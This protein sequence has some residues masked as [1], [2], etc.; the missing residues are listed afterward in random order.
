MDIVSLDHLP[1][2]TAPDLVLASE[3]TDYRWVRFTG[4]DGLTRDWSATGS[5]TSAA[6][7]RATGTAT[8][9]PTI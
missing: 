3:T 5:F 6:D 7:V 2:L 8:A 1:T 9:L 4:T